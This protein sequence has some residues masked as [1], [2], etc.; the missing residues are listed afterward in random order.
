MKLV[1]L[2]F[3]NIHSDMKYTS[4][5][6]LEKCPVFELAPEKRARNLPIAFSESS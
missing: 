3:S 1:K 5:V 4:R 2:G 6:L